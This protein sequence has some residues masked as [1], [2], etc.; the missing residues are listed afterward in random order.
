MGKCVD[1]GAAGPT[2]AFLTWAAWGCGG[3][4]SWGG[5]DCWAKE[6]PEAA[7]KRTMYTPRR[8]RADGD[9]RKPLLPNKQNTKWRDA[10]Q[11]AQ[12]RS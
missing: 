5:G 12:E 11:C 6:G 8:K 1:W 9:S 7:E 2:G 3:G 4:A 10:G